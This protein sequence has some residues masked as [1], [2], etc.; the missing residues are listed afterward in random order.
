[1]RADQQGSGTSMIVWTDSRDEEQNAGKQAKQV[2][3]T[4]VIRSTAA[5]VGSCR[6]QSRAELDCLSWSSMKRMGCPV[7]PLSSRDGS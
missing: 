7:R 5:E 2:D 4:I 3:K 6:E 1:M